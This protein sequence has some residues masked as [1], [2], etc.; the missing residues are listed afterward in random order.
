MAAKTN[1]GSKN[2]GKKK[3]SNGSKNGD[4]EGEVDPVLKEQH[5]GVPEVAKK[6]GVSRPTVRKL[7]RDEPGVKFISLGPLGKRPR[8]RI[9]A[10]VL[11]RVFLKLQKIQEDKKHEQ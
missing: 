1:G 3:S 7:F 10:S 4:S 2:G 8:M 6:L 9:P 5:H 11:R